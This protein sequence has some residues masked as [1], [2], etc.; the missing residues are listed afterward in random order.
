LKELL[1]ILASY[2]N[3][4]KYLLYVCFDVNSDCKFLFCSSSCAL[5]DFVGLKNHQKFW[6]ARKQIS[7]S[8]VN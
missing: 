6:L 2:K 3:C 7:N 8:P 1:F 4:I 5:L